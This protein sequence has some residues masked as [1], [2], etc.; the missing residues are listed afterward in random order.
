MAWFQNKS[1]IFVSG[2]RS[3]HFESEKKALSLLLLT[4]EK[5]L[6]VPDTKIW[7]L[8]WNQVCDVVIG[9]V[10]CSLSA[11]GKWFS[12]LFLF[13]IGLFLILC[14]LENSIFAKEEWLVCLLVCLYL[15]FCQFRKRKMVQSW[16]QKLFWNLDCEV[17]RN[18]A[19]E[20]AIYNF[21][22][23]HSALMAMTFNVHDVFF[24]LL[25]INNFHLQPTY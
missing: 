15:T 16:F 11:I 14:T 17:V 1:Q 2:T 5:A 19:V 13:Y 21:D 18:L 6:P 23:F 22:L 9:S 4:P 20:I 10:I 7:D 12:R 3:A 24:L 25:Q 8:F